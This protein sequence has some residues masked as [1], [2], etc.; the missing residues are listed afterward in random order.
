MTTLVRFFAM[1]VALVGLVSS[2]FAGK[3]NYDFHSHLSAVSADPGPWNI[4]I[5]ICFPGNPNCPS[6]ETVGPNF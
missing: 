2:S 3:P 5:P 6:G 4:P 1:S